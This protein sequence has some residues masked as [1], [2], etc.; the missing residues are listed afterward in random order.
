MLRAILY[1]KEY[2]Y[3]IGFEAYVAFRFY[4]FYKSYDAAKDGVWIAEHQNKIIG[5]LLLMHRENNT[6]QLRFFILDPN[7]RNIGLGKKMTDLLVEFAKQKSYKSI[8]LW[9]TNEQLEAAM[10]YKKMGFTLSEEHHS[11]SFGKPLMEQRY[12]LTL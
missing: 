4:E 12:D 10:L 3:D 9:T 2:G 7:Y 11:T 6:G 8:Y 1:Q 5:F